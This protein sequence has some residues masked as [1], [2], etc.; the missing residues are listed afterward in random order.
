MRI[1]TC[2]GFARQSL[3]NVTQVRTARFSE[4]L[5]DDRLRAEEVLRHVGGAFLERRTEPDLLSAEAARGRRPRRDARRGA[6]GPAE[7]QGV[8]DH[9]GWPRR[10]ARVVGDAGRTGAG[11]RAATDQAVLRARAATRTTFGGD[12]LASR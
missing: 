7:P 6:D 3:N 1:R 11:A 5:P 12:A 8:F 9:R 4:L 10:T 2:T